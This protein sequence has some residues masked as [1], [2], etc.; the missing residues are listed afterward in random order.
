MRTSVRLSLFETN[1]S[2]THAF[3]VLNEEMSRAFENGD[4]A[5]CL[6]RYDYYGGDPDRLNDD[7]IKPLYHD[8]PREGQDLCNELSRGIFTYE[9]LIDPDTW[10]ERAGYNVI[11]LSDINSAEGQ[12]PTAWTLRS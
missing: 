9:Q 2:S 4:I 11:E 7:D 5:V 1:S 10:N 6:S 8:E 12:L 3:V